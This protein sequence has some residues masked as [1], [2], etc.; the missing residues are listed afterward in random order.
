MDFY[1]KV[2]QSDPSNIY[3]ANGVGVYFAEKGNLNEARDFFIQV[4]EATGDMPDVWINLAHV[5]VAQGLYLNAIKLV[6]NSYTSE[7]PLTQFFFF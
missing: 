4:R 3:A 7:L 6:R 5:Y 1:W 2:L